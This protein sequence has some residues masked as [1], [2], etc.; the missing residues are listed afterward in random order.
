MKFTRTLLSTVVAS[1]LMITSANAEMVEDASNMFWGTGDRIEVMEK[2]GINLGYTKDSDKVAPELTGHARK[3]DQ[4]IIKVDDNIFMA[5]GFGLDSPV[6]IVGD[7]GVIIV[8]PGESLE[9][10]LAAKKYLDKYADGKPVVGI[11]YTHNHFDHVGGVRAFV[12]DEDVKSGN[13]KIYAQEGVTEAVANWS[14][15]VGTILGHRTGY[16]AAFYV[17]PGEDGSV[18]DALGPQTQFGTTTFIVPDVTYKDRLVVKEGGFDFELINVPSET[19]DETV[20]WFPKQKIVHAAEVLQGENFP[21]LHSI[22]GT[23]FRNPQMWYSGIDVMRELNAEVMVNSH[24]RPV[25]GQDNVASVLTDYRDAIQYVHDQTIRYMNMGMTPDQLVEKV[26]LPEHLANAPWNGEF[27]GTVNHAVRQMYVGYLGFF[28]ADPWTLEPMQYDERA[29][30]M[31]KLMGGRDNV[32]KEA[33]VAIRDGDFTWAAEIMTQVIRTNPDD[34]EARNLKAQA[35]RGW[36]PEVINVN[37]RNWILTAAAELEDKMD[38]SSSVNFNSPDVLQ[39]LPT[40]NI[41][42]MLTSKLDGEKSVDTNMTLAIKLPDTGETFALEI[43]RGVA[44]FYE[45]MPEKTDIVVN[46]NR[47][48]LNEA[49]MGQSGP[50]NQVLA[51][52]AEAGTFSFEKGDMAGLQTFLSY[53]PA[54]LA[55]KDIKLI[56]R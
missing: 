50:M 45:K 16:T 49:L 10:G 46:L 40:K 31:V 4:G 35:Y 26:K 37:W 32:M 9:H 52:G 6:M 30:R 8:D 29:E 51:K 2:T 7:E 41:F 36:A 34:M 47:S 38:Y 13:V 42:A 11:I 44:Q 18:N 3:M 43:R 1:A 15:N 21:N 33:K 23:K 24:G 5:Y 25:Q 14:S 20:V 22:R 54:A 27:Y 48:L 28:Q 17:E 55:P 53:F 39:A 19:K 56:V 12:N